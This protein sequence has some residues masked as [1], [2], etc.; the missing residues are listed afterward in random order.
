MHSSTGYTLFYLLKGFEA[1]EQNDV[2]PAPRLLILS[3]PNNLFA[4]MWHEAKAF[5]RQN[6]EAA[7]NRTQRE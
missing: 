5:P 2:L 4:K 3:D 7:Q 6:L 1:K